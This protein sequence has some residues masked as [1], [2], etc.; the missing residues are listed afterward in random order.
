MKMGRP[1]KFKS[2]AEISRMAEEYFTVQRLYDKPI[3]V[4]GLCIALGTVRHVLDDYQAG[5]HDDVDPEFSMAVKKAKLVCENYAETM[6][7]GKNPVGA[8]FALKNFGW[9]DR[10]QNEFS[11]S[12]SLSLAD[13]IAEARKRANGG[14]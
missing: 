10:V 5:K 6:L 4:T 1:L 11:G 7:F 8:I 3:T 12:I 13:S 2:A 14:R 9:T